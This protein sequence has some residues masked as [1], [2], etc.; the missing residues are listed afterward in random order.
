[1]AQLSADEETYSFLW[2]YGIVQLTRISVFLGFLAR[3]L[4][5]SESP[6][7][8]VSGVGWRVGAGTL[9][10]AQH[11]YFHFLYLSRSTSLAPRLMGRG[12]KSLLMSPFPPPPPLVTK[13]RLAQ[14]KFCGHHACGWL[15]DW[16]GQKF[17]EENTLWAKFLGGGHHPSF[18]YVR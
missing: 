12:G 14:R 13:A 11:V 9:S 16:E 5:N 6:K 4:V 18:G 1:M 3:V 8:P 7:T 10:F 15:H 2:R 17:L